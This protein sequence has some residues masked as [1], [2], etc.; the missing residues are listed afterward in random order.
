MKFLSL[1]A[2]GKT[3]DHGNRS[4]DR[5]VESNQQITPT[6]ISQTIH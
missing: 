4:G 5:V 3:Q 6:E 1:K 2:Q